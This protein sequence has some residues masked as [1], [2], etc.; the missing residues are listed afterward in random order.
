MHYDE[1]IKEQDMK[2]NT[3]SKVKNMLIAALIFFTA[4][5]VAKMRTVSVKD[6]ERLKPANQGVTL[7]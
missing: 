6:L 1:N 5:Q 7:R 3:S 4:Y 2:T